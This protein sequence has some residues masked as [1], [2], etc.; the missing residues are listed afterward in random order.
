MRLQAEQRFAGPMQLIHVILP[1][2]E[3]DPRLPQ[4]PHQ[5]RRTPAQL[6]PHRL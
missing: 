6:P 3:K 1:L 4:G 5:L 2:V